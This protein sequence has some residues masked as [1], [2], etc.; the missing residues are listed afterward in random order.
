MYFAELF[1]QRKEQH[2]VS[3]C[4]ARKRMDKEKQDFCRYAEERIILD[5]LPVVDDLEKSVVASRLKTQDF[6]S[7]IAGRTSGCGSTAQRSETS[8][9]RQTYR[10][11]PKSH[12]RRHKGL[13]QAG[14]G[15]LPANGPE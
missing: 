1:R 9:K 12:G 14:G 15:T 6:K 3:V 8:G 10:Q 5:L 2:L 7:F 13:S 4:S 11:N